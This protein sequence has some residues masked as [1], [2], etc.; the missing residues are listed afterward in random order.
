MT[1]DDERAERLRSRRQ[2]SETAETDEQAKPSKPDE[3]SKQAKSVATDEQEKQDEPAKQQSVK[4]VHQPVYMY[5]PPAQSE[6]IDECIEELQFFY[7]REYGAEL[8]KNR[9]C[10]PLIVERGLERIEQISDEPAEVRALLDEHP[11]VDA[12]AAAE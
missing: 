1:D 11:D 10:L 9:H 6:R 7:K 12:P 3:P 8:E 5:L 2:R 4:E